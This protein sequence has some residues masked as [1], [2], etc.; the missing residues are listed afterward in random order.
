MPNLFRTRLGAR[1]AASAAALALFV[2]PVLAQEVNVY[3]TRQPALIKPLFDAFTKETGVKVNAIFANEGL[4]ERVAAEGRN[5]PADILLTVDI[6]SLAQAKD[7]G[8]TQPIASPS[9][10]ANVPA[11]M[12]DAQGHWTA[13]SMRARVLYASK[14]RVPESAIT[15]EELA[16]PKWKG[17]LCTRPGQHVYNIGLIASMVTHHGADWTENWLRGVKQNLS[18]KPSGSDRSQAKAVFAGECDL[19]FANTYYYG[20]MATNEKEPE[21]KDWA[22]SLKVLFPNGQ[23]R[24]THVNV[25]GAALIKTA[26]HRADAVRFLE[27]MTGDEA[28][29]VYAEVNYEYPVKANV[30]VTALIRDLGTMKPDAV[31]L[32]E[33]AKNRA[34]ATE[35]VDK[36]G[37]DQ[38]P[39]A[40]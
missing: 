37:F 9:L 19:A 25:S 30:P 7:L 16:D 33:V 32:D 35:L 2:T 28:Q 24:G 17:R 3:T 26:P 20:L 14:D 23:N 22:R 12:R 11:N 34:K 38:G 40:S 10:E 27:F 15:Y 1:L 36:V 31:S 8:I 13:L 21:Q 5:S 18:A 39:G 4:A 6:G 29:R